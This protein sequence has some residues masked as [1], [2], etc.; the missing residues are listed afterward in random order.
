MRRMLAMV[1]VLGLVTA[2]CGG[3]E[4]T[5][6]GP[7]PG[8]P[9]ESE[10]TAEPAT[11]TTS[12]SPTGSGTPTTA[13]ASTTQVAVWLVRGETLESVDRTV[14]RV[15]GIGAEAV[16][17]LLAGPTAAETRSGFTSAVPKDTRF[18]G[19]VIDG[20]GIAKVD[21]TRDF[22]SGGG[23]LGLTLRLAQGT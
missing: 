11:S 14:P 9:S 18:I 2:A 16:K 4:A 17:A 6:A 7:V 13:V 8:K 22:E 19:L 23:S 12:P 10:T 21:L 1:A 5:D 3:G 15:P 20:N